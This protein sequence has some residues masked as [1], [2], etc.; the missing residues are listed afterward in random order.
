MFRT[1]DAPKARPE[2]IL[3]LSALAINGRNG[4]KT[5]APPPPS[6]GSFNGKH[7]CGANSPNVSST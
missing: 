7:R 6:A 1:A 5:V 4:A 3:R 2:S